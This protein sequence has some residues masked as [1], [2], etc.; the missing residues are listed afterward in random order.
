MSTPYS[1]NLGTSTVAEALEGLKKGHDRIDEL[2]LP[3]MVPNNT[4]VRKCKFTITVDLNEGTTT[5]ISAADRAATIRALADP[6]VKARSFNRPGHIFPLLAVDGGVLSRAGHTEAAVDLARLA[7]CTP[8]AYICEINDDNGRMLRRPQLE[9]FA[10][11]HGLH[12]ITISD[13][14]RYRF[15]HETLIQR[16]G[17]A[18]PLQTPFGACRKVAYT[19]TFDATRFDALVVGT[20]AASGAHVFFVDGSIDGSIEA[21]FA[22]QWLTSKKANGVLVF[23]PGYEALVDVSGELMAKQSIFGMGLQILKEM[24]ASSAVLLAKTAPAFDTKGFGTTIE[25]VQLLECA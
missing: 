24:G 2:Q 3:L 12:L 1:A 8:A 9:T 4:E 5:G 14:I 15:S 19:T 23:V 22:L 17:A 13:L 11:T 25:R 16:V 7:G 18:V 21:Q 10:A 6:S 20:I